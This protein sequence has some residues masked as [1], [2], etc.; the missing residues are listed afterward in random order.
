MMNL[1]K[2]HETLEF[3]KSTAEYGEACKAIV[4]MLNKSGTG[5]IYFGVKDNGDV[6]GHNIGKDTLSTLVDRIKDSIKPSI[7]PTILPKTIGDKTIISVTFSGTNKPYSYKGSFYIRVEQQNLVVDPLVL[8]ELIKESH[9]YNDLWENEVTNYGSEYID[10]EAVDMFYRQAVSMGRINR[11]DHSSEELL[12][13][14][15][16]MSGGKFTNAGLYLFGKKC[17]LV[18]KAVEYPTTERLN[19][20]DLKRFE[21]NIFN[22]IN[23]IIN[24]INQKMSWKVEVEGIQ[25]VEKPEI[26]V[27]AIREIVIN[28]LVHCDYHADSEHQVTIDPKNIEVYN[29]GAFGEFTPKDYVERILPSR[30]KHKI[31]QG[32]IFKAFDVETLGR[33][34][35]RM[36]NACKE[37]NISWDFSKYSFGFSFTFKRKSQFNYSYSDILSRDAKKLLN[38][39][40]EDDGILENSMTAMKI[41]NKKDRSTYKVIKELIDNNLIERIGSNKTGYWKV[42]N[43]GDKNER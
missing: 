25:R 20:I 3:K 42:K 14:L 32:I 6:I 1:G 4:A 12:T 31:V 41:L 43:G 35:K 21:G 7:Y 8:R 38:F 40:R 17:P 18:Y 10:H 36:D 34:L 19:P 27:V 30:T 22:L 16:L 2:E 11:F 26:P 9:E 13:Q 24:F 28:S 33:G 5:S 15:N 39:M 23:Q 29:P 37:Y